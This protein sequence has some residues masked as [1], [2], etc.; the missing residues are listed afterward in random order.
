MNTI[1][2]AP[3]KPSIQ[4]LRNRCLIIERLRQAKNSDII[5]FNGIVFDEPINVAAI[6]RSKNPADKELQDLLR[7]WVE[8]DLYFKNS[9]RE[10]APINFSSLVIKKRVS[11]RG[12]RFTKHV[13]F[14]H[15]VFSKGAHFSS[16]KFSTEADFS[17]AQFSAQA[18]FCLAQFSA[19]ADF[20]LSQFSAEVDFRLSKF[21]ARVNFG[22]AKFSK[23]ADFTFAKFEQKESKLDFS[24]AIFKEELV[25]Q[26]LNVVPSY[27]KNANLCDDFSINLDNTSIKDGNL[28]FTSDNIKAK[29]LATRQ[30]A[31]LFKHTALLY[32][33]T[34]AAIDYKVREMTLYNKDLKCCKNFGEKALL[35][36]N[37]MS[38]NYGKSWRRGM[39]FTTIVALI[40]TIPLVFCGITSPDAKSLELFVKTFFKILSV[41]DI[42]GNY[43]ELNTIGVPLVFFSKIFVSYGIY[44]TVAAFRKHGK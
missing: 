28:L 7:D 3:S 40:F 27:E 38:N 22:Y 32:H 29:N 26:E 6:L 35:W 39:R 5:N 33:D 4:Q 23:K 12:A 37:R 9:Y 43:A 14:M 16:S 20:R 25:L 24:H 1:D 41:L 21:S 30:T 19:E 36:L 15:T 8:V 13:S 42:S 31:R 17:G 34:V 2:Q 11:F 44:Q 18:D 10:N